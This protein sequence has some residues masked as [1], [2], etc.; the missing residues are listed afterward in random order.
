MAK[1]M[2]FDFKQFMLQ[3]G[4]RVGLGVAVGFTVLL[5]II[6]VSSGLGKTSPLPDLKK[7]ATNLNQRVSST[8]PSGPESEIK[9]VAVPVFIHNIVPN[10]FSLPEWLYRQNLEDKKKRNPQ[11]LQLTE[12][13]VE[14][15]R[16]P[17]RA[18]DHDK[19]QRVYY[20][21]EKPTADVTE[22]H[23]AEKVQPTRMIMVTAAFPYK[24]EL[25]EFRKA[26]RLKKGE[27]LKDPPNFL[28]FA[29]YRRE[30]LP[31]GEIKKDPQTDNPNNE[32]K[33]LD[34]DGP[35]SK[36]RLLIS[37]SPRIDP[38]DENQKPVAYPGLVMPAPA[39]R[40]EHYPLIA[41]KGIPEA[42]KPEADADDDDGGKGNDPKQMKP[43]VNDPRNTGGRG[44]G[45]GSAIG[46]RGSAIGPQNPMGDDDG[47]SPPRSL[48]W[49]KV[50]R[51]IQKWLL[52]DTVDVF[53]AS[54]RKPDEKEDKEGEDKE[55]KE[56]EGKEG[57]EV[58][59]NKEV[60][61]R[62][63]NPTEVKKGH[64]FALFRFFDVEVQPGHSYE[65]AIVIRLENPNFGKKKEVADEADAEVKELLSNYNYIA[66]V[67]VPYDVRWY[68]VD[69]RA[70]NPTRYAKSG[71]HM[72][73]ADWQAIRTPDTTVAVQ[74]HRWVDRAKSTKNRDPIPLGA[75]LVAERLF[76]HRG[77]YIG[78]DVEVDVP[79]W[80][81][82]AEEFRIPSKKL[83]G[84]RRKYE[85]TPVD[86][87]AMPDADLPPFFLVDFAGGLQNNKVGTRGSIPDES[88]VE[89]LVLTPEGKLVVRNSLDDSD[90]DFGRDNAAERKEHY[91]AWKDWIN[92]LKGKGKGGGGKKKG[93]QKKDNKVLDD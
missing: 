74:I 39:V 86:F 56:G 47:G 18:I 89:M 20:L 15:L 19:K 10:M 81:Q 6:G 65:Y 5:I 30:T 76:L 84:G 53:D 16:L 32:W 3:K 27:E 29:V 87:R 78:R 58:K 83:T 93:Q 75:W 77:E 61:E 14:V 8:N 92:A 51:A 46:P 38:L 9:P 2:N 42:K 57:K 70:L 23:F 88:A 49:D 41:L 60:V 34:L 28:G 54:G 52:G 72:V 91:E 45:K 82:K 67:T 17:V 37:N 50:P 4:E 36:F 24:E 90:P 11:V 21:G 13:K 31:S 33:L 68:A 48:K 26:L 66:K 7:G 22:I 71:E 85:P 69:Q 64:E 73:G 55:G 79:A 44:S 40:L 63:K 25:K 62:E 12:Y 59:E 1:K 80:N 35:R 43:P